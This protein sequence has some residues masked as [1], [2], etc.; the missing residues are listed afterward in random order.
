MAEWVA[1]GPGVSDE[2]DVLVLNLAGVQVAQISLE[3]DG[4][5]RTVKELLQEHLQVAHLRQRLLDTTSCDALADDEPLIIGK[6]AP[7]RCL[8][9]VVLDYRPD[10][11]VD[12]LN[13]AE[14]GDSQKALRLLK[15]LADPNA[16][17]A[18]G[19]TPLHIAA[20]NGN[21]EVARTLLESLADVTRRNSDAS[22]ALHVAAWSGQL[23]MMKALCEA[24]ASADIPQNE[25]WAPIHI[26]S[27]HGHAHIV[28][29]LLDLGINSDVRVDGGW[30]AANIATWADQQ[31]VLAVLD[32]RSHRG[33]EGGLWQSLTHWM[34][35]VLQHLQTCSRRFSSEKGGFGR[36]AVVGAVVEV[37]RS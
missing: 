8:T 36:C 2:F 32:G 23:Q 34:G 14:E 17:E 13:A 4:T 26:A 3:E 9:L 22:T 33:A 18:E 1:G 19:W 6:D 30:T 25:G 35:S 29:F 15:E 10:L 11:T 31:A 27:R 16:T 24:R 37:K 28:E 21:L 7:P 12:L 20:L 5:A